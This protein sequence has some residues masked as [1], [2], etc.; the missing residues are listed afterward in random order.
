MRLPHGQIS[1]GAAHRIKIL[2]GHGSLMAVVDFFQRHQVSFIWLWASDT[3]AIQISLHVHSFSEIE[4]VRLIVINRGKM[5]VHVHK[6][7]KL[8]DLLLGCSMCTG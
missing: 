5:I 3:Y 4:L 7:I 6:D 2:K 1:D 8:K